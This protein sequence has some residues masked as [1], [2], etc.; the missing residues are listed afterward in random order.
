MTI[1]LPE[2]LLVDPGQVA[3]GE[4]RAAVIDDINLKVWIRQSRIVDHKHS[5]ARF[6]RTLA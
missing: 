4:E 2:H 3:A 1:A 6:Q 5:A